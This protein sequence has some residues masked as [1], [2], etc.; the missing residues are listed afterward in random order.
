MSEDRKENENIEVP[1]KGSVLLVVLMVE[2][3]TD[4]NSYSIL[5]CL[6]GRLVI[7]S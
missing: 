2:H 5:V 1:K 6:P 4:K 3:D 7:C